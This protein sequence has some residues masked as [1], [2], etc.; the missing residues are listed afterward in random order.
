MTALHRV[1]KGDANLL[2]MED[3]HSPPW[4]FATSRFDRGILA[5]M[6]EHLYYVYMLSNR[7]HNVLYIGV[8]NSLER[9][10]WEHKA[11][12]IAGFTK[13]YNCD[14]LMYFEIYE[15]IE[16]ALGREKQLKDWTRAKKD[17]LIVKLNPDWRDLSLDWEIFATEPPASLSS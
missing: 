17:A 9:R 13:K 12:L 10:I 5:R 14:Q 15:R 4:S 11:K 7:W 1:E 3:L 6:K 2:G 16:Q 8:T